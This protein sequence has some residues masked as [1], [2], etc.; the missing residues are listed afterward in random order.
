MEPRDTGNVTTKTFNTSTILTIP[1]RIIHVQLLIMIK[2]VAR[3]T[4]VVSNKRWYSN[5]AANITGIGYQ[6][7]SPDAIYPYRDI[8]VDSPY[9]D[10]VSIT[11]GSPRQHIWTLMAGV[12][13]LGSSVYNCYP[14][15]YLGVAYTVGGEHNRVTAGTC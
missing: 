4:E 13:E 9:V 12:S 11:G 1:Q 7:A 3:F 10:G 5:R 14:A 6:W 15:T 2:W 8:H